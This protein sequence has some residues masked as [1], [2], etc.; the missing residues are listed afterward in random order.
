MCI[1]HGGSG[2]RA[3]YQGNCAA[4]QTMVTR[5]ANSSF[6]WQSQLI[7]HLVCL[8]ECTVELTAMIYAHKIPVT[9]Y[10]AIICRAPTSSPFDYKGRVTL[11]KNYI[12]TSYYVHSIPYYNPRP[13]RWL[14]LTQQLK[15]SSIYPFS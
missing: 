5:V 7:Q 1:D 14:V 15:R 9:M 6:T 4:W 3:I 11:C 2:R 13:P 10:T 8:L 12:R